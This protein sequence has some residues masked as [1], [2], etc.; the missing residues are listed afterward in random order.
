[1]LKEEER[2]SEGKREEGKARWWMRVKCVVVVQF[3]ISKGCCKKRLLFEILLSRFLCS[4]IIKIL[5]LTPHNIP[6]IIW[7]TDKNFEDPRSFEHIFAI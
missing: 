5:V 4:T 7:G 1:M 3:S 2:R 6:I